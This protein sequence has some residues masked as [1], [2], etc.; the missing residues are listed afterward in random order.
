VA[1][2]DFDDFWRAQ[3]PRYA[4][5]TDAISIMTHTERAGLGEIGWVLQ[6]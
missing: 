5:T 2:D 6:V 4:P 3:T 1:F